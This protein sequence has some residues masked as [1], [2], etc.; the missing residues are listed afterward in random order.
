EEVGEQTPPEDAHCHDGPSISALRLVARPIVA[1]TVKPAERRS[2]AYFNVGEAMAR[3]RR[4]SSGPAVRNLLARVGGG[5][6]AGLQGAG[7][8]AA[9]SSRPLRPVRRASSAATSARA[10]SALA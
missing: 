9:F 8:R 1:Q 6:G 4:R 7:R 3:R 5:V 2:S 10:T